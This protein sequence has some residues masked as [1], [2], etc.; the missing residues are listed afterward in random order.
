MK[1]GAFF[2]ILFGTLGGI[3]LLGILAF[4]IFHFW[5]CFMKKSSYPLDSEL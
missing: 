3:L 1:L 4:V 5:G 2:G